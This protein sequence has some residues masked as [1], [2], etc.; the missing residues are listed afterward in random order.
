MKGGYLW[1]S[2][3]TL[4]YIIDDDQISLIK[5]V[6]KELGINDKAF[7]PRAM[8][9]T[10][11]TSPRTNLIGPEDY[12]LN[13]KWRWV[14]SSPRRSKGSTPR[15]QETLGEMNAVDFGDLLAAPVQT[16]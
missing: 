8:Q 5:L 10:R 7:S 13:A 2:H 15:Y 1:V 3:R 9:S 14:V 11:S 16:L 12:L 4:P 6:M